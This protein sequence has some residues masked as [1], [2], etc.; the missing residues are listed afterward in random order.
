MPTFS[1]WRVALKIWTQ[2][3]SEFH[4]KNKEVFASLL[5][6]DMKA[7]TEEIII[8]YV[9]NP[10]SP[11]KYFLTNFSLSTECEFR[12]S[13]NILKEQDLCMSAEQMQNLFSTYQEYLVDISTNCFNIHW[14]GSTEQRL[15]EPY[16]EAEK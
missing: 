12:K 1:F 16:I 2:I 14:C 11:N 10:E 15:A 9:S 13:E 8:E 5:I 7:L 6:T 4:Q 3:M